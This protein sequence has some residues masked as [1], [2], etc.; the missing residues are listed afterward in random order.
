MKKVISKI[1]I[2]NLPFY[3]F[4]AIS[5]VVIVSKRLPSKA[6]FSS[7]KSEVHIQNIQNNCKEICG[8]LYDCLNQNIKHIDIESKAK[9]FHSGCYDGCV[10]HIHKLDDCVYNTK[11]SCKDY[12]IC[13]KYNIGK[14]WKK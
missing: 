5:L 2:I 3:F 12:G 1:K 9:G 8:Y 4:I 14:L 6:N 13:F 10:K 7:L 11:L